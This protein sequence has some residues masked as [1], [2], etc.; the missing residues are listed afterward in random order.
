MPIYTFKVPAGVYVRIKAPDE[1]IGRGVASAWQAHAA[2]WEQLA[3][4]TDPGELL[5]GFPAGIEIVD[6]TAYMDVWEEPK[7]RQVEED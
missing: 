2:N 1:A 6:A 5:Q 7:L 3:E 4:I